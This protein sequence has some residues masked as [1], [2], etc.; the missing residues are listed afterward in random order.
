MPAQDSIDRAK[1]IEGE[2][3]SSKG[4]FGYVDNV[5]RSSA[6]DLSHSDA[7][8]FTVQTITFEESEVGGPYALCCEYTVDIGSNF[9]FS[10]GE[11]SSVILAVSFVNRRRSSPS[12]IEGSVA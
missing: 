9:H 3:C 10:A 11:N 5:G 2:N 4:I 8:G 12:A 7:S 6:F 1:W